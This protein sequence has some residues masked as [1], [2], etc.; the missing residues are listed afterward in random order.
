VRYATSLLLGTVL[1]LCAGVPAM[2]ADD[3]AYREHERIA[4]S[5]SLDP[6]SRIEISTIPGP[7]VINTT[8]GRSA[9]VEVVRAAA[10]RADLDCGGVLIEQ[11]GSTLT[12]R[13]VDKCTIV[14]GSQTVTL[15]VPRDVDLSLRN[16]AGRVRIGSTD[17]MVYLES[18]AGRVEAAGLREARMSSLAEGLELAVFDLGERGIRVSSVR[19]GIDLNV[20]S[21][22]D[23]EVVTRSVEGRIDNEVPG[24]RITE[25]DGQNQ[26]ALLGSG[27]GKIQIESV[28]GTVKIRGWRQVAAVTR[29]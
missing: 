21:R 12:I 7:V 18:I 19:G 15:R 3:P 14:R 10:T 16:I 1:T 5:F 4:K 23:A 13:S 11:S 27:R 22:I 26:R 25:D 17:G 2:S 28:V 20:N 9:D 6:G 29:R 24:V 8:S